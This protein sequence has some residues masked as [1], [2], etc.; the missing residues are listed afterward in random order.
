M[1][2]YTV[3]VSFEE[4]SRISMSGEAELGLQLCKL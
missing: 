1:Y 4:I 3:P 2:M